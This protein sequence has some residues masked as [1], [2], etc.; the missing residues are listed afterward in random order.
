MTRSLLDAADLQAF[1]AQ[2]RDISD[3]ELVLLKAHLL[4][5][6]VL[7]AAL[8]IRLDKKDDDRTPRVGFGALVELATRRDEDRAPLRSFN[9][10]RNALAH[11][12]DGTDS[13]A[14]RAAMG[15]LG[16]L[17]PDGKDARLTTA[18]LVATV[19]IQRAFLHYLQET[20][21][22][23]RRQE[24]PDYPEFEEMEEQDAELER[25]RQDIADLEAQFTVH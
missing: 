19:M 9:E 11:E 16:V 23:T 6:R 18:H 8:V 5:E 3:P 2:F 4:V 15:R 25:I 24:P 12:L 21:E 7:V 22:E 13:S 17:W 14:F 1:L 10:L 20:Y